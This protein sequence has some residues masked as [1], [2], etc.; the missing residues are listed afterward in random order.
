MTVISAESREQVERAITKRGRRLAHLAMLY[1]LEAVAAKAAASAGLPPQAVVAPPPAW[2]WAHDRLA[3]ARHR[4][5]HLACEEFE[6]LYRESDD[7]CDICRDDYR[8]ADQGLNI[9]H[10]HALGWRAVRGLLCYSCNI[11]LRDVDAGRRLPDRDMASYLADPWHARVG[12]D[13]LTCPPECGNRAHR[14]GARRRIGSA[15]ERR[16]H[17]AAQL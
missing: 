13:D 3:C 11:S 10:D 16:R 12:I 5:Y 8:E 1:D 6:M 2:P 9:D 15:Y 17:L 4:G 14:D 7:F